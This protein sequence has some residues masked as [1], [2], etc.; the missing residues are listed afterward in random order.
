[1][2]EYAPSLLMFAAIVFFSVVV[3]HLVQRGR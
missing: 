1:M 2:I 3:W